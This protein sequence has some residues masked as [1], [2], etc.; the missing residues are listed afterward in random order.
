M[1]WTDVKIIL[2]LAGLIMVILPADAQN[3]WSSMACSANGSKLVVAATNGPIWLSTNAG[4]NWFNADISPQV[5][6]GVAESADGSSIVAVAQNGPIYISTNSGSAWTSNTVPPYPW[7]SVTISADGTKLAV[8]AMTN[9]IIFFSTNSGGT[10]T[11]LSNIFPNNGSVESIASSADG[12]FISVSP[13]GGDDCYFS[14]NF[15]R[16]W[17]PGGVG[18]P[19]VEI[20][21]LSADAYQLATISGDGV[22]V[23]T[24]ATS[25]HINYISAQFFTNAWANIFSPK[26]YCIASSADGSV[27]AAAEYGAAPFISTDFGRTW[28]VLSSP[29][30][31]HIQ[32][33]SLALSADGSQLAAA[34]L[35]GI[36][37]IYHFGSS[38]KL[39][40]NLAGTNPAISWLVPSTNFILQQSADLAN[41]STVTNT[42]VFIFSNLENQVTL[43]GTGSAFFR[44]KTP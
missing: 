18:V 6:T 33:D 4:A 30:N 2:G 40:I 35:D 25:P 38:P 12:S 10:W 27:L 23:L 29:V 21:R 15:G 41:W 39:G 11:M 28:N 13:G 1:K 9:G 20:V 26:S 16:T 24:N 43:P 44:L 5:W 31:P 36:I 42:P 32:W 17:N 19:G 7:G 22:I 8:V 14:T 3:C 34:S 37:V